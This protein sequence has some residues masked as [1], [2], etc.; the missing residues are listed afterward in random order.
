[1]I[2]GNPDCYSSHSIYIK[3]GFLVLAFHVLN[4]LC[5]FLLNCSV[6]SFY[7]QKRFFVNIIK[8]NAND[9]VWLLGSPP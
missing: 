3:P 5:L 4:I 7:N 1:M 6:T 8:S 9:N 2:C